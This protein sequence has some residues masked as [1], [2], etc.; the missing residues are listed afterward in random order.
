MRKCQRSVVEMITGISKIN[1]ISN[2]INCFYISKNQD[3]TCIRF[4]FITKHIKSRS[5][6]K[7]IITYYN[8]T[9][10]TTSFV[11]LL[12]KLQITQFHYVYSKTA[13]NDS[14]FHE[15]DRSS[16]FLFINIC[17]LFTCVIINLVSLWSAWILLSK[18]SLFI[19]YD[20]I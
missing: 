7:R 12:W 16:Y 10:V 19:I 9:G 20:L 13:L 8:W 1:R 2:I 15:L 3:L 17:L 5:S 18:S 14:L 6:T 4:L 11:L